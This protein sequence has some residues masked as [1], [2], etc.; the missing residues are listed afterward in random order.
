MRSFSLS[1]L[2]AAATTTST[3]SSTNDDGNDDRMVVEMME[4]DDET[5]NE[6]E[7]TELKES[8]ALWL[9]V[10]KNVNL[11]YPLEEESISNI[12]DAIFGNCIAT[13]IGVAPK[14][15][16]ESATNST[17]NGGGGSKAQSSSSS[18]SFDPISVVKTPN[19]GRPIVKN[20][21][22]SAESS[23][24]A[25]N[26][27]QCGRSQLR[28]LVAGLENINM[29]L[30]NDKF[31]PFGAGEP[32]ET[33]YDAK[34][35]NMNAL[36]LFGHF[37]TYRPEV[38][39]S[40]WR[41]S[42]VRFDCFSDTLLK[43]AFLLAIFFAKRRPLDHDHHR[44]FFHHLHRYGRW[45]QAQATRLVQHTNGELILAPT[46]RDLAAVL[47]GFCEQCRLPDFEQRARETMYHE[48]Y[49]HDLN[50]A[51]FDLATRQSVYM[52]FTAFL[53]FSRFNLELLREHM[54]V[55]SLPNYPGAWHREFNTFLGAS[56]A[57]KT[58]MFQIFLQFVYKTLNLNV[59]PPG[60]LTDNS[61][62]ISKTKDIACTLI[63]ICD[64][65]ERVMPAAI[66]VLTN[67]STTGRDMNSR[68][69]FEYPIY[70]KLSILCNDPPSGLLGDAGIDT[71][72]CVYNMNHQH[73]T[74]VKYPPRIINEIKSEETIKVSSVLAVQV[75][76][77]R[78]PSDSPNIY[79]EPLVQITYQFW[80]KF[81]FFIP[82]RPIELKHSRIIINNKKQLMVRMDDYHHF[83]KLYTIE[84]KLSTEEQLEAIVDEFY[85]NRGIHRGTNKERRTRL[86]NR[87][88]NDLDPLTSETDKFN[89]RK[90]FVLK[91]EKNEKKTNKRKRL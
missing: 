72:H 14:K 8:M 5:T 36:Q 84:A 43:Q 9:F 79:R 46:P 62:E 81:W 23:T 44:H 63:S 45:T 56:K 88:A 7:N 58:Q 37:L 68:I 67:V 60:G 48:D 1:P 13:Q 27:R 39:L 30:Q 4:V 10:L 57:G 15:S 75:W 17:T 61:S 12:L 34:Y 91:Q 25:H 71:R 55:F 40:Q 86:I 89:F 31:N 22:L 20:I 11:F 77:R 74:V 42:A 90:R 70:T 69:F 3:T 50:P 65:P 64:E 19:E 59:L 26:F 80:Q 32:D 47:Q 76:S 6:N 24:F 41:A 29:D 54:K 87:L 85:I 49:V 35:S 66:K 33:F 53:Y 83:M 78:F 28:Q 82:A 73:G 2:T 52:G 21:F 38:I 51:N 18:S 16:E